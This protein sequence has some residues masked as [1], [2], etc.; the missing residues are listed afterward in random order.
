MLEGLC[1]NKNVQK[2]L[3]F[4]FVN[5][6]CYGAQLQRLLSTPLTSLQNAFSRLEKA[7]LVLS[8]YEGKTKLYQLNPAH[9]LMSELE[10]LLKRAFTLLPTQEKKLYSLVQ[11]DSIERRVQEPQL[12][13]F[14]DKLKD[15]RHFTRIASSRSQTE[16]KWQGKG[17]G[18]VLVNEQGS[19]ILV[20]H[21]RGSWEVPEGKNID[22]SNTFRWTI[23]RSS[24]MISLEHL[25]LGP[26]HPVFLFHLAVSGNNALS[27][28]E[29]HL[30][31]ED[32][33]LATVPWDRYSIQLNWRV[34]GPKK[35]EEMQ[36]AYTTRT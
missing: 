13:A 2:I 11:T 26:D 31:E 21:E 6:K 7:R 24:C 23:D 5:S 18:D 29:S 3:L 20:F 32:A 33:Y 4:L 19:N 36:S 10:Q 25:R 22:F 14:W 9:P 15:V 8:Y 27:S 34:I 35:N 16:P 28:V 12:L 1:G 30:C 17:K